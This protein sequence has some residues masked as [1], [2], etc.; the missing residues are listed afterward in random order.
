MKAQE[1]VKL[2]LENCFFDTA[3]PDLVISEVKARQI[4]IAA[5]G[6]KPVLIDVKL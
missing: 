3:Y 2:V 5:K 1:K 6:S 4:V